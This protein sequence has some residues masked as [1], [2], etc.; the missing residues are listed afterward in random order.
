MNAFKTI[1]TDFVSILS[2]FT[3]FSTLLCC[4]LPSLLVTLSLGA[5]MAGLVTSLPFLVTLSNYKELVFGIAAALIGLNFFLVYRKRKEE[6]ACELPEDG[7]EAACDT[8]SRWSRIILWISV[9]I[10]LIGFFMAYLALPLMKYLD[11]INI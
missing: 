6:V 3:S 4:A 5:V 9:G 7:K 10:L 8:A 11:N 1:R 2:L